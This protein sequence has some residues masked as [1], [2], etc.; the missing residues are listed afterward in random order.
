[1]LEINNK[2]SV[3]LWALRTHSTYLSRLF[4]SVT[5]LSHIICQHK[6]LGKVCGL[7]DKEFLTEGCAN[8]HTDM[9]TV[10]ITCLKDYF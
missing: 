6:Y 4:Q 8:M 5:W 10:S 9:Q 2:A 1:M 7:N 3:T